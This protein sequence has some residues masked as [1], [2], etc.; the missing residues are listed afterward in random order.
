[1]LSNRAQR[2]RPRSQPEEPA[3]TV[4]AS[5]VLIAAAGR[6]RSTAMS[7]MVPSTNIVAT[8][9]EAAARRYRPKGALVPDGE[10]AMQR[11]ESR[12]SRD[13]EVQ[14]GIGAW[15]VR[16]CQVA[17]LH[18]KGWC[19]KDWMRRTKCEAVRGGPRLPAPATGLLGQTPER[20]GMGVLSQ[21]CC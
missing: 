15:M 7:R 1:M 13:R 11:R 21:P 18:W 3:P 2:D 6:E 19:A 8:P 5:A 20:E 16:M 14:V 9:I 4:A 17:S 10:K 12:R